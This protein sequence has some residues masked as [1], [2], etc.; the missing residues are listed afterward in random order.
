MTQVNKYEVEIK[1]LSDHNFNLE[2]EIS[3]LNDMASERE[4]EFN[5]S[6]KKIQTLEKSI[7][8]CNIFSKN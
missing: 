3:H 1:K 7:R 4:S 2:K 8:F 5:A 6:L